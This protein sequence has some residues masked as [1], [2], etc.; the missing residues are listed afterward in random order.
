MI[1]IG[2]ATKTGIKFF[3]DLKLIDLVK[4]MEAIPDE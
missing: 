3:N 4:W 1:K 2:Q